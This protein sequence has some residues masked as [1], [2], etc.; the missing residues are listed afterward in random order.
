MGM[1][2]GVYARMGKAKQINRVAITGVGL[3]SSL[4][5][6]ACKTWSEVVS[7]KSGIDRI[8]GWGNLCEISDKYNLPDNF[9]L[10]AGEVKRFH[11]EEILTQRKNNV[12]RGDLKRI[13][14]MD[15]FIQYACAASLEAVTDARL[16]LPVENSDCV[17]VVIGSGQGGIQTWEEQHQRMLAG[18]KVSPFSIPRQLANLASGNVSIL[19][20]TRGLNL[21]PSTACATGAHALGTAFRAIQLGYNDTIIAGGTEAAVTPLNVSAFHALK[22]LSTRNGSPARASRPFDRDRDGF[23]M[24]EGAGVMILERLDAALKRE[25]KIYAEIIGYA[26]TA[27]SHH[28]TEPNVKGAISC[29]RLA[30]KDADVAPEEVDLVNAHAT[31]TPIGDANEAQA[32]MEIFGQSRNGP[33]I[34]A[35]KSQLGHPL[36]AA[37]AIEAVLTVLS[38]ENDLVP[39]IAN[40]E[41]PS[42]DCKGLNYV[43][44]RSRVSKI[45]VAVSNSFGFGGTNACLIFRKTKETIHPRVAHLHRQKPLR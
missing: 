27:D 37:G 32:L 6:D 12:T 9:P 29:M 30:L 38:M 5:N 17:G 10:F 20:G 7:G 15:P 4:G 19:L 18:K 22:A 25:A 36:G 44:G 40:L 13:K 42:E 16:E 45:N 24:A 1:K 8:T 31:S 35:N 34:T 26:E 33:A 3:V 11:F 14:Q 39:P 23:V 43:T 21:C 2:E 28:I 41:S